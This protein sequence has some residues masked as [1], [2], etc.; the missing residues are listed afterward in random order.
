MWEKLLIDQVCNE[1]CERCETPHEG[2]KN[3][4]KGIQGV[5]GIFETELSL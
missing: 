2:E 1:R 4:E 3:F 5:F